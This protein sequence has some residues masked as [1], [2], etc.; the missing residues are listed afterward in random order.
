MDTRIFGLCWGG[1]GSIDFSDVWSASEVGVERSFWKK[2]SETRKVENIALTI[3]TCIYIASILHLACIQCIQSVFRYLVFPKK[4][5]SA[6]YIQN[7]PMCQLI[8]MRNSYYS[9]AS[10][11]L[12]QI[13]L[14]HII[15]DVMTLI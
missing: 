2:T 10:Y 11:Y 8:G 12:I 14:L 15:C 13:Y 3:Y 6:K 9:H 4:V 7:A 5:R 1:F